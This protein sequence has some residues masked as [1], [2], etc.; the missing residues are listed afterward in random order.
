MQWMKEW[1]KVVLPFSR[2][3]MA[4][5]GHTIR[6]DDISVSGTIINTRVGKA[7]ISGGLIGQACRVTA[8]NCRADVTIEGGDNIG[9]LWNGCQF[10]LYELQSNRKS[11]TGLWAIGGHLWDMQG[12]LIQ[13]Q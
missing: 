3:V 5:S 7:M 6:F 13:P 12:K 11:A 9:G 1:N 4:N 8:D 2:F 10:H